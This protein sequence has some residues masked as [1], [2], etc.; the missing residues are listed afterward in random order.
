[1]VF[2]PLRNANLCSLYKML[3]YLRMVL[4]LL[5][6]ANLRRLLLRQAVLLSLLGYHSEASTSEHGKLSF[7]TLGWKGT[8]TIGTDNKNPNTVTE[9]IASTCFLY[10]AA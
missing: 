5:G 2:N 6:K 3:L 8:N 10:S 1:M 4:R 7:S 9:P